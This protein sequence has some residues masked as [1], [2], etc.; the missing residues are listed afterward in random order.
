MMWQ[1]YEDLDLGWDDCGDQYIVEDNFGNREIAEWSSFGFVV[2][3]L[4]P[5]ADDSVY[6]MESIINPVRVFRIPLK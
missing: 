3:K 1:A 4:E 6:V 2:V 5:D